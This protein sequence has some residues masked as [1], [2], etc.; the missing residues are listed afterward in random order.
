MT[1]SRPIGDLFRA[2]YAKLGPT[3]LAR[4]IGVHRVTVWK[5]EQGIE[6]PSPLAQRV[7]RD[8]LPAIVASATHGKD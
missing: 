1:D 5:W 4:Q 6:A 8:S 3:D 2:A 7:L